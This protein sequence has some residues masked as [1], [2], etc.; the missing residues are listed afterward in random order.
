MSNSFSA[1]RLSIFNE[2]GRFPSNT[3]LCEDMY[4]TA[5]A[6]LAG[7]KVAYV[8]DA[9][10]KH[11]HN[12]SPIDEFK[13]YFDIGVFHANE[14]WIR[15]NFGGAGG[16]GKKFILS[17]FS[18]L[19]KNGILWIPAAIINNFMKI[20]GYKLGLIYKKLPK[21]L[22]IRLSMHRRYWL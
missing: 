16:E 7:Y 4:Y 3:I 13:R 11:S 19:Y 10:V 22:V 17:E 5:K 21:K 20:C 18:Y 8:A 14:K 2:I 6:I 9:V 15:E 12:Y 1:Y